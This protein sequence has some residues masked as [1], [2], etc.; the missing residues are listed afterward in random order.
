[1]P[2]RIARAAASLAC[3]F[4]ASADDN[5]LHLHLEATGVWADGGGQTTAIQHQLISA[6]GPGVSL[7]GTTGCTADDVATN[8]TCEGTFIVADIS[9]IEA[10]S[11]VWSPG[12]DNMYFVTGAAERAAFEFQGIDD[13]CSNSV[14]VDSGPDRERSI[15][16]CGAEDGFM[17]YNGC[18]I[19]TR[20]HLSLPNPAEMGT[21]VMNAS[22]TSLGADFASRQVTFSWGSYKDFRL[23]PQ[24][25]SSSSSIA[26]SIGSMDREME[27]CT[28]NQCG[29]VDMTASAILCSASSGS[30]NMGTTI[31]DVGAFSDSDVLGATSGVPAASTA[32]RLES[33]LFAGAALLW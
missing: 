16:G 28:T 19:F 29:G 26:A 30:G 4:S 1:M 11:I 25:S 12:A 22:F 9:S 27:D 20:V 10:V 32:L 33:L 18:E 13:A 15:T 8:G 3:L 6:E 14:S 23:R 24:S 5:V 21:V 2:T 31:E 17:I 7:G